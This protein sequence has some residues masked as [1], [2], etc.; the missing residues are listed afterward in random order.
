MRRLPPT[1]TASPRGPACA[2]ALETGA[3]EDGLAV[4]EPEADEPEA[5]DP[6][7][8]ALVDTDVVTDA[9]GV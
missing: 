8:V 9:V 1:T 5:A 6:V 4:D 2:P 7:A 3:E